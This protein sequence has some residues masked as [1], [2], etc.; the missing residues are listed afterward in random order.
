[1]SDHIEAHVEETHLSPFSVA[2]EVS[3]HALSGDEPVAKGGLDLAPSPYDYLLTALGTCTAITVRW[4]AQQKGWP[5]DDVA[6]RL[7]Y[8]RVKD[9]PSGKADIYSKTVSLTGPDLT[10]EQRQR[11]FEVAAKCPVH[12]TL[13][14]GVFIE[15]VFDTP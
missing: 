3:G 5:L 14:N 13:T 12:K 11:L 6:V 4:Y 15:S 1:M 10:D 2:V 8:D 9:H 7:T